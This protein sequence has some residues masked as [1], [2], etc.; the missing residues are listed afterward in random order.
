MPDTWID[1]ERTATRYRLA[2][3]R[4]PLLV[5]IHEM[6][7]TLE[8][9]DSFVDLMAGDFRLLS[10]DVRGSGMAER[11]RAPIAIEELAD[12]LQA[13]LAALGLDEP[14]HVAGCAVGGG[15]A[16]TFAA[17]HPARA[18]SLMMLTPALGVPRRDRAERHRQVDAM[19]AGGVRAVATSSL[20][21]SYPHVLRTD[22]ARF[23][24][25]KARWLANDPESMGFVYRMLIE[26]DLASTLAAIECPTLV[27]GA[28]H[29]LLRPPS[30][31]RT[32]ADAVPGAE[33]IVIPSGHHMP[34]QTPDLVADLVRR[35]VAAQIAS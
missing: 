5:L 18:G 1:L 31:A 35:F 26:Q 2:G 8:T 32:V 29:D 11:I 20:G 12:D 19:V 34:Y 3:T 4:G 7:G 6:G 22:P 33:F 16:A 9:W 30:Y 28:E 25:Y 23:A 17:R 21:R 24:N 14:C 15:V 10:Y 13:L 27:V